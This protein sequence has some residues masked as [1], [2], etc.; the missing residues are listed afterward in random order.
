MLSL[1]H[2]IAG[3]I[4]SAPLGDAVAA[5]LGAVGVTE[6]RVSAWLGAPC[7]CAE[8]KEKLNE[9]SRR[10]A[11]YVSGSHAAEDVAGLLGGALSADDPEVARI[12]RALAEDQARLQTAQKP[13]E[14]A[15]LQRWI[16]T[17][18]QR[19]RALGFRKGL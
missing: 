4:T 9:F 10:L 15:R 1:R 17:Y 2:A 7:A 16:R 18:E 11:G 5:A 19:L 3:L 13:V 12:L 8:R 14:R 6:E